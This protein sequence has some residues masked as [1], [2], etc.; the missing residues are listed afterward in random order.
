MFGNCINTFSNFRTY[1]KS[2][3]ELS[4]FVQKSVSNRFGN[5]VQSFEPSKN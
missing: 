4:N 5:M 1:F 3:F 2:V